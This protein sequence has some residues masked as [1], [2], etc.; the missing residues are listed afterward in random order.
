MEHRNQKFLPY[1]LIY[2]QSGTSH[3]DILYKD[4]VPFQRHY[5]ELLLCKLNTFQIQ[6]IRYFHNR[7]MN[8][9]LFPRHILVHICHIHKI[10]VLQQI[11]VVCQDNEE[12]PFQCIQFRLDEEY[13][14][15]NLQSHY[16][17]M[18]LSI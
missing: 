9:I 8:E 10:L 1:S 4:S 6:K 13:K 7:H 11:L 3:Q 17:S 14:I 12:L 5:L 2:Q 16:Q 18:G 15:Q